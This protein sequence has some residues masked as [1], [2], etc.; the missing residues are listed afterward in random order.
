MH[1]SEC[2]EMESSGV[3]KS[4]SRKVVTDTRFA[5]LIRESK[6]LL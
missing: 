2:L 1:V 4:E 3:G 5:S 6:K